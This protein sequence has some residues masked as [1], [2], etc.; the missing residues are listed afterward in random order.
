MARKDTI[1]KFIDDYLHIDDYEDVCKNGLQVE[2]RDSINKIILGVSANLDL[3]RTASRKKADMV[4]V[5]HGLFWQKR[6]GEITGINRPRLKRLLKNDI[7]LLVYHLPLDA[8]PIIGNN[9]SII[10]ALNLVPIKKIDIGYIGKY[11]K[12]KNRKT[13]LRLINEKLETDSYEVFYGPKEVKNVAILS[14]GGSKHYEMAIS[15]GVDTFITGDIK[16]FI[17]AI[18]KETKTNFI[19]AWHHNTEK[20]GIINLGKLLKNEFKNLEI[21]FVNIPNEV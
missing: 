7:N 4:I 13:F 1:I 3:I 16:E 5:H 18:A 14:G 11:D 2:G 9:I 12:P 17:P 15:E 19:N 21:E 20:F 10:K 6:F 8:H